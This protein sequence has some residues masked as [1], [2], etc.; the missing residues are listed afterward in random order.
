MGVS[1][2]E[3][4]GGCVMVGVVKGVM[5]VWHGGCGEGVAWWV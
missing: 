3:C 1:F 5:K 2:C 4:H